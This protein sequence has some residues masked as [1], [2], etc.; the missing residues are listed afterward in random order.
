M[1]KAN[2][3][4]LLYCKTFSTCFSYFERVSIFNNVMPSCFSIYHA[5]T[6][7]ISKHV[8]STENK[9]VSWVKRTQARKPKERTVSLVS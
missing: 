7:K 3:F 1:L 8:S 5:S 6:Q 9:V 2:T 4:N